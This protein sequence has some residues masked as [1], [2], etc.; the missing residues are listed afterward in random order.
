MASSWDS[1]NGGQTLISY[2]SL[3]RNDAGQ[4]NGTFGAFGLKY[5]ADDSEVIDALNWALLNTN[6]N[7]FSSMFDIVTPLAYNGG[8]NKY[9]IIIRNKTAP[10]AN[11]NVSF[12]HNSQQNVEASATTNTAPVSGSPEQVAFSILGKIVGINGEN[13]L[14]DNSPIIDLIM[15]DDSQGIMP[16]MDEFNSYQSL[17]AWRGGKVKEFSDNIGQDTL[18]KMIAKGL[19]FKPLSLALTGQVVKCEKQEAPY[20]N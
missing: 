2:A 19:F 18:S 20:V 4:P 16:A 13:V 12:Q 9:E 11:T 8:T 14:I 15:S 1:N 6:G 10:T 17:V 3:F 7:Y 5:F